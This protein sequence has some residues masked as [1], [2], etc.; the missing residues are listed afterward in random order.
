MNENGNFGNNKDK[1]PKR[2]IKPNPYKLDANRI[3]LEQAYNA[4]N[5]PVAMPEKAT[6][7]AED[8][9]QDMYAEMCIYFHDYDLSIK[10][11]KRDGVIIPV[12]DAGSFKIAKIS[13]TQFEYLDAQNQKVVESSM[14]AI[15]EKMNNMPMSDEYLIEQ[16]MIKDSEIMA[17]IVLLFNV[18]EQIELLPPTPM[19]RHNDDM[20]YEDDDTQDGAITI[21]D[22][23]GKKFKIE[24]LIRDTM[25]KTTDT[26]A[27]ELSLKT[28][29]VPGVG[30]VMYNEANN[31]Y[32]ISITKD[33][34]K[35]VFRSE[36]LEG[37]A[38]KY[39]SK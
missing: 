4:S 22:K 38:K 33:G 3:R 23:D 28:I 35:K 2:E 27:K 26:P 24:S 19:Y 32:E 11:E 17:K 30:I 12:I 21:V 36:S 1:L 9:A 34:S 29:M 8:V 25:H 14:T 15:V 10:F 39:K 7:T 13:D 5:M 6:Q 31:Y 37:L 18:P 16:E 20:E